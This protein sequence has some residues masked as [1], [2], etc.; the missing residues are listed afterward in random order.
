MKKIHFEYSGTAFLGIAESAQ[1]SC[2]LGP[3][4]V[5][6]GAEVI[7]PETE[8]AGEIFQAYRLTLDPE[9]LTFILGGVAFIVGAAVKKYVELWVETFFK[10]RRE[11]VNPSPQILHEELCRWLSATLQDAALLAEQ[12][13]RQGIK[14]RGA[15]I[16]INVP[17]E[18]TKVRTSGKFVFWLTY[19]LVADYP[20]D[21]DKDVFYNR[22]FLPFPN[23]AVPF[24][25]HQAE[26]KITILARLGSAPS[27][28]ADWQVLAGSMV[29][30]MSCDGTVSCDGESPFH[31]KFVEYLKNHP[32]FLF[33]PTTSLLHWRSCRTMA[34]KATV[35][36]SMREGALGVTSCP[37]CMPPQQ[38]NT[39]HDRPPQM[40]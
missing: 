21:T 25:E 33:D 31:D 13:K 35:P 8:H 24:I 3:D 28:H 26:E 32:P 14:T 17:A 20:V 34:G 1:K 19:E 40:S 39:G 36:I 18:T 5:E 12:D 27:M 37:I 4:F 10:Q 9:L 7:D 38:S 11:R 15:R 2:P 29:I 16:Y 30:G 23:I 22:W 6:I